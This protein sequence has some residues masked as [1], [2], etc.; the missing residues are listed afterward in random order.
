[1]QFCGPLHRAVCYLQVLDMVSLESK[2]CFLWG[3]VIMRFLVNLR[4]NQD[5]GVLSVGGMGKNVSLS[6]MT[7]IKMLQLHMKER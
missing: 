5:L 7:H 3:F 4:A 1:M 6:I 2:P